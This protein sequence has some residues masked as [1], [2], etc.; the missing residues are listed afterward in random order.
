VVDAD[1]GQET[2]RNPFLAGYLEPAG[3]N[4][5]GSVSANIDDQAMHELYLWPFYDAVRA[6]VGSV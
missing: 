4:L 3:I 2:Q 1:R 6:G 5:N